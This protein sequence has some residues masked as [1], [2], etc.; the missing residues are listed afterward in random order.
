MIKRKR[1]GGIKYKYLLSYSNL[2]FFTF[3]C[4][5]KKGKSEQHSV[6][7]LTITE[8]SISMHLDIAYFV[9]N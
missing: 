6:T 4:R 8:F 5:K 9:E 3:F 1:V 2:I 7:E